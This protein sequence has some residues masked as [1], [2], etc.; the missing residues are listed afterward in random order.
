ML[1]AQ[2]DNPRENITLGDLKKP[3]DH[4]KIGGDHRAIRDLKRP[5]KHLKTRR[6]HRAKE[7]RSG[8]VKFEDL[9]QIGET[10]RN[11]RA[12]K[13]EGPVRISP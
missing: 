12:Q 3:M 5:M 7:A 6:D 2:V 9:R 10:E 13:G 4:L 11:H 1:M 8:P